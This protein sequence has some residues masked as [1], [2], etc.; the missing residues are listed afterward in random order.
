MSGHAPAQNRPSRRPSADVAEL[1]VSPYDN[2]SGMILALLILVGLGVCFLFV[3][4]LSSRVYTVQRVA[5]VVMEDVGGGGRPDGFLG[6]SLELDSPDAEEISREANLPEP[7]VE[8]TLSLVNDAVGAIQA[9]WDDPS[10]AEEID[11][12]R[13]GRADGDGRRPG[14][15]S[16][17]GTGSG[18]GQ[19]SGNAG[20]PRH[21]RWEIYFQEGATLE[22]YA[23]QLDYFGIEL[24]VVGDGK[25][26]YAR[27]LTQAKPEHVS[28]PSE[29][30]ERLY[31]SWR[32]G[33]LKKADQALLKRAGIE[34]GTKIAL[35]FYP[36]DVENVLAQLEVA[37]ANRQPRQ[38]R[39]TRFGVRGDPGR[40]EFY[41]MDQAPF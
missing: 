24:G 28:G 3:L 21:N 41:V 4:W 27:K 32:Q 34:V 8:K 2:V 15:G 25:V 36:A 7:Q 33:D 29:K 17:T 19:G 14:F 31:M 38:I 13:R 18:D 5:P 37:F 9:T 16:G 22:R 35:Q 12:G 23:Q 20:I 40:F 39:R 26:D 1:R 10:L 30:E 6:E 11:T